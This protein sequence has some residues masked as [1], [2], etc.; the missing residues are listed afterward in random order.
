MKK[1]NDTYCIVFKGKNI[2][3][4]YY[5]D[6]NG[7]LKISN[8]GRVFRATAEQVLNHL[9]PAMA[10]SDK[11]GLTVTVEHYEVPYWQ[12]LENKEL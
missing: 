11:L 2:T 4:C 3:E 1:S 10:L 9:L 5:R 12:S 8:K 6:K 7:W